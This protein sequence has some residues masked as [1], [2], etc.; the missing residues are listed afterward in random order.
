MYIVE[1]S[2]NSLYSKTETVEEGL[3]SNDATFINL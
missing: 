3:Q 1:V 2:G